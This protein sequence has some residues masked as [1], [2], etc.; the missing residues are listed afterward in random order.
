MHQLSAADARFIAADTTH[1]NANVSLVHIYDQGTVS[2]GPLRFKTL[3]AHIDNRLAR[4]PV[5][6]RRLQRVPFDVDRPYWVDDAHFD[7][8][9]HVRHIALPKPG[10]WRQFCIQAARIHS[11]ALDFDRPLWEIYVIEGLDAFTDLPPGSFALLTKTHHAALGEGRGGEITELLHDISAATGAPVPQAPWFP[12]PAPH[13]A[14]LL[15]RGLARRVRDAAPAALAWAGER[16]RPAMPI[17]MTRF[18]SVVSAHRVFETRRFMLDDFKRLRSLV[19]GASVNDVVLAVCGGALRRYLDGLDELPLQT[20]SA[21]MPVSVHD[22]PATAAAHLEWL[23]IELAT[24]IADPLRRL[25]AVCEQTASSA[26]L[27][28]AVAAQ[29]LSDLARRAGAETLALASRLLGGASLAQGPRAPLANVNI[30]NMPGPTQPLFL[31]GARLSYFSALLPV[32]DGMGLSI[33]VTSVEGRI[34]ISPTA[35]RELVPQ[36]EV[37][38]ACL[39]ASFQ[40]LMAL[41]QVRSK[42]AVKRV[43]PVVNRP[44]KLALKPARRSASSSGTRSRAAPAA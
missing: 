33:A 32:S 25:R 37:F 14:T 29:E 19:D 8:E 43:K 28:H 34:V 1:A 6:R 30:S 27:E 20:L 7:I 5:F 31:C 18:G 35:C 36:P 26:L 13:P 17:P 22:R 24:H 44:A 15:R 11:R 23:R 40:E 41:L 3:L 38:A 2:D 12:A 16:L 21:V 10:D 42:A 9:Y 39:R 4:H